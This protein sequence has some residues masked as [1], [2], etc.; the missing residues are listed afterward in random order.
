MKITSLQERTLIAVLAMDA[1]RAVSLN[2]ICR[3][4]WGKDYSPEMENSLRP[5]VTRTRKTL[6]PAQDL[7]V[8]EPGGY[9][10][11]V[12]QDDVDILVFERR[13][14]EG[15]AAYNAGQWQACLESL[16]EAAALSTDEPFA[17]IRSSHLRDQQVESLNAKLS[18]LRPRRIEAFI[19]VSPA[20]SAGEMLYDLDCLI[21]ESP[22]DDHLRWLRILALYRSGNP[23]RALHYYAETRAYLVNE[24][25][26]EP[27]QKLQNLQKLILNEDSLLLQTPFCD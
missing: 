22:D 14:K 15:T 6:G 11:V 25:G 17:N 12:S 13:V 16:D 5:L 8:T 23:S 24:H 27:S 10:L 21:R 20:R 9:R 26:R 4:V 3:A 2:K 7:I 18:S 1:G 19:R